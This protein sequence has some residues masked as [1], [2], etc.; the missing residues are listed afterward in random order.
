MVESWWCWLEED[1]KALACEAAEA[2]VAEDIIIIFEYLLGCY[3][4][5]ERVAPLAVIRSFLSGDGFC[6]WP[7]PVDVIT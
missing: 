1:R 5:Y 7:R 2:A 4:A 3:P 6:C